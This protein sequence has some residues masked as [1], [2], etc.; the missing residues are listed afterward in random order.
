MALMISAVA[1]TPARRYGKRW[2]REHAARYNYAATASV[3]SGCPA[4]L[5]DR[6]G[7]DLF[8]VRQDLS[9]RPTGLFEGPPFVL[10]S[11]VCSFGPPPAKC[12]GFCLPFR[13]VNFSVAVSFMA[14]AVIL[15]SMDPRTTTETPPH[16]N[17]TT[18]PDSA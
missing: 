1:A 13:A 5:V 8:F 2:I 3:A 7:L 6:A 11:S 15:C 10:I 17:S 18:F 16:A 4:P 9:Q 12:S 14:L